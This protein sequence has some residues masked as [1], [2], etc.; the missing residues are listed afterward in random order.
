M[1][2]GR[3]LVAFRMTALGL[4]RNRIALALMLIL[5]TTFYVLIALTTNDAPT[6]FLL[7]SVA[8]DAT[9]TVP[10][11]HEALVFMGLAAVGFLSAFLG[12][13]LISRQ[14]DVARRLLLCGYHP[15]ELVMARLSVLVVAVAVVSLFS[16]ALL[17]MFFVPRHL[18][19]VLASF[20]LVGFVYGCCGLLAGSIF[21]RELEG[22][23]S[24]VL[25][26]N[27]DV[28]W[29]Q[30]PIFYT[31]SE[32]RDVIQALPAYFPAQVGMTS[33]FSDFSVLTSTWG[34]LAY[35]AALLVLA[36]SLFWSRMHVNSWRN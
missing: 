34:S 12:F 14:T 21:K 10:R 31:A 18:G 16:L 1:T 4:L 2:W 28:G 17:L 24:I 22:I 20:V 25:I 13:H 35:G 32:R 6:T 5:P 19:G 15:W 11:N 3:L 27:V 33:A 7:P 30:N 8:D 36:V 26:T 23:L 29:L 9:V